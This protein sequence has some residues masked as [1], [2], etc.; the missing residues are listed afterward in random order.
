MVD[1]GRDDLD[2]RLFQ[3]LDDFLG[4]DPRGEIDVAHREAQ[5]L[6]ADRSANIAGQPLIGAER[7]QQPAH[8]L[9]L[10]PFRR[11]ERQLH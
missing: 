10:A 2:F 7:I 5:Q 3:P 1:P 11:V 8:A 4:A 6:V 9:A